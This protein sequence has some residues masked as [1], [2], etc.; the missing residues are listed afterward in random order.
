MIRDTI[1]EGVT[2]KVFKCIE[3]YYN[4]KKIEGFTETIEIIIC[5]RT[6]KKN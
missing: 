4:S 5:P 1:L 2:I 3:I 6:K